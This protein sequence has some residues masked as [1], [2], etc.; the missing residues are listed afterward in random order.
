M[1]SLP[2]LPLVALCVVGGGSA[3]AQ[4]IP[5]APGAIL[6]FARGDSVEYLKSGPMYLAT[7]QPGFLF[8]FHPF[9]PVEDTVRLRAIGGELW[10]WLRPKLDT[11]PTF[12]VLQANTLRA[13]AGFSVQAG[14]GYNLVLERHSDAKWYFLNESSPAP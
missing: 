10:Q 4:G 6:H 9:V 3:T 5:L 12:V 13:R 2:R 14:H 8:A 11:S 7:G 1:R